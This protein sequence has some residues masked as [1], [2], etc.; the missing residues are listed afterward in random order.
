MLFKRDA[1]QLRAVGDILA[2]DG[3]REAFVLHLLDR[4]PG[5]YL[6][7]GPA[8]LDQRAGGQ[9]ARELVAREEGAVEVA[10]RF[11][12]GVVGVRENGVQHLLRPAVLAQVRDADKGVL[13]RRGMFFVVE[14]VQETG[15][16][17]EVGDRFHIGAGAFRLAAPVGF[18][19]EGDAEGVLAQT[20]ARGPLLHQGKGFFAHGAPLWILDPLTFRYSCCS[21]FWP[22]S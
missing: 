15:S 13:G 7:E 14:V 1:E 21:Y 17:V 6:R 5:F 9:E 16:G 8:G 3:A 18:A 20:F 10:F 4:A 22:S 12:A 11:H 19:A 2:L